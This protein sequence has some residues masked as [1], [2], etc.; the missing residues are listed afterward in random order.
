MRWA[1]ITTPTRCTSSLR[2]GRGTM[3]DA[4][5]L[6]CLTLTCLCKGLRRRLLRRRRAGQISCARSAPTRRRCRHAFASLTPIIRSRL[7][8]G[9]CLKAKIDKKR[10][11]LDRQLKRLASLQS[12]GRTAAAQLTLARGVH[13]A[14][15]SPQV[16]PAHMDEMER[17]EVAGS[18]GAG[19][20]R[21]AV[22]ARPG[23]RNR[24]ISTHSTAA[25]SASGA[26]SPTSRARALARAP[27]RFSF[28]LESL[29]LGR[30]GELDAIHAADAEKA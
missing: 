14:H 3:S 20:S 6:R 5:A 7:I 25:M 28:L 24:R 11:E 12:V 9:L 27:P 1:S 30:T 10:T 21:L 26:T 17:L 4:T 19:W 29:Y 13:W 2:G 8:P 22:L 18:S 15:P 23:T 16:R